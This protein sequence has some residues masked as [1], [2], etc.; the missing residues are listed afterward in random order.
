[1]GRKSRRFIYT[2]ECLL[3]L[4]KIIGWIYL[5]GFLATLFLT[6]LG[7]WDYKELFSELKHPLLALLIPM[8]TLVQLAALYL[9]ISIILDIKMWKIK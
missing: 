7:L 8:D 5:I 1:M 6:M 9:T 2:S 3:L 4:A